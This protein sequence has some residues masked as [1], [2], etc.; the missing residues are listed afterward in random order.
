MSLLLKTRWLRSAK[1]AVDYEAL[2]NYTVYYDKF[3]WSI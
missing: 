2:Y 3:K 1:K